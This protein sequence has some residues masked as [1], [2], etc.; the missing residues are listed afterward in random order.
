MNRDRNQ[1]QRQHDDETEAAAGL[2]G[3][4]EV[5]NN[6]RHT[7]ELF[8]SVDEDDKMKQRGPRPS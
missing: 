2:N 3:V 4:L 6:P 8:E 1:Q 7:T 5:I